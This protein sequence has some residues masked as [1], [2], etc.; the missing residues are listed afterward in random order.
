MAASGTLARLLAECAGGD[1]AS[2]AELYRVS[3]PTLFAISVRILRRRDIA[4]EVLQDAFV[5]IWRNAGSY[6]LRQGPPMTWMVSI[7]RNRSIDRLRRV[8]REVP[9][10]DQAGLEGPEDPH[11]NPF[12]HAVQ[13]AQAR[14]LALCLDELEAE[15]RRC[16]L[17]AY[18]E[19]A[20][21]ADLA[22]RLPAPI[23]TIK[24]RIRRGLMRLRQCLER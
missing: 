8:Q 20:S 14:A 2:L 4:E 23:G 21:H 1:R 12:E 13:N 18:Y 17:M 16:I 22:R 11:P 15:Q 5:S 10:E 7:V 6:D 3:G 9:L 19:G 24:S